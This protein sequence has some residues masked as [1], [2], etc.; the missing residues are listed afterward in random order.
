MTQQGNDKAAAFVNSLD[1]VALDIETTGLD[2]EKD[3]IIEIAAIRFSQGQVA[4]RFQSFVKP[5]KQVP[6]FI[7]HLTRISAS[8]LNDAPSLDIVLTQLGEFVKDKIIVGHNINFDL[9]FI[10]R[11]LTNR[12]LSPLLNT[13]WDTLELSRIYFPFTLDH[14]LNSVCTYLDIELTDAH[15][16]DADATATGELMLAM[17]AHIASHYSLLT[18]ARLYELCKQAQ[19]DHLIGNFLYSLIEWQRRNLGAAKLNP[20][21]N[22][23]VNVV[24]H[25]VEKNRKIEMEDFFGIGGLLHKQFDNYEF[26]EGQLQM[27]KLVQEAFAQDKHLAV[28]AGTGVGK[29]FA[30]LVPAI[31]HC[32]GSEGTVVISTNTKNL[33]EQLFFKDLPLLRDIL[34]QSFKAVLVKGRENYICQRRWEAMLREQTD[35]L[36]PW[37]ARSLLYLFVWKLQTLS[38][39]VSENSSFDRKRSSLFWRKINSDRYSCMGRRCPK[40]N[41]CYVMTLRKN[42][43]TASLVV[44]NHSLLLADLLND[45]STLGPYSRLVIDEAHNLPASAASHLGIEISN[46]ELTNNFNQLSYG[47]KKR[48]GF[49]TQTQLNLNKAIITDAAKNHATQ[50]VKMLNEDVDKLKDATTELFNEVSIRLQSDNNYG[51]L[52]IKDVADFPAV[53]TKLNALINNY[54]QLMKDLQ[55]LQNIYSTFN[56][57]Q[58][59]GYAETIDFLSATFKRFSEMEQKLLNIQN[60]NLEDYA[61]W[62]SS[63]Y[64]PDRKNPNSS[65]S[66]APVEVSGLLNNLL[67]KS[68]ESIVFTSAT[69]A[70]R[71][72]F[73]YFHNQSGLSQL[74]E[75]KLRSE[76]V[77]SPFDYNTQ[78]KLMISSFLPEHKDK[79]FMNQA[80]SCL[81]QILGATDVGT[82]M[83]FTSYKDLNTVYDHLD[84]ELYRKGRPFFAQGKVGTR[85]SILDEFKRHQNAV[86]LGTN[87]FWEGVDIQGESLSLLILFKL[88]FLVPSEPIV[89]AYIDKLEREGKD[90]FMHYMLPN[91]LLRLRQG[92]GRLI[93]SK[94]DRGVVLIM[95]SRVSNKRYGRF[96]KEVLPT[97]SLELRSELE[98]L[99]EITAFFAIS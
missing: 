84:E 45:N 85:T 61:L 59:H 35:G 78:S 83:L 58:I 26:R 42:I 76:I 29:S 36:S 72:S 5:R 31:G 92:F 25:V 17:A 44:A 7:Q 40:A 87:S 73:K 75:D 49:L 30:Y 19:I 10:N 22:D 52:R 13:K 11:Q 64:S 55:A 89:E 18:N 95:D 96:F 56:A 82:M 43:E 51:K 14:S 20:P 12:N 62:L 91:A 50:V 66:Y 4:E 67:Y 71:G 37:D 1:F 98:L 60:P 90:S 86:L 94:T 15:R 69:L 33:Q 28:E 34:P 65:I 74:E 57:K 77:D 80:L 38:G 39:D 32:L 70:I 46:A 48:S 23:R 93:R 3:E 97:K 24:E 16:A 81:Q 9:G 99:N 54:K 21:P 2:A 8:E 79:F 68:V 88:P 63:E 47:V 27:S 41:D 53:F 6:K